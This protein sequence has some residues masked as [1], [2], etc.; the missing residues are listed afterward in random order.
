MDK[1]SNGATLGAFRILHQIGEGG[2]ARVYKAYQPSME[3]YVA[4]KVLPSS[5]AEDPQ[6]VSRFIREARTIAALEHRNILPVIDFGEERGITYMAMRFVEGGTLKELLSKGRLNLHDCVDLITQICSA[7]DYAHRRGVIHRDVKP[8]NVILDGEGAA[9]L[10]DF[11]IAKVVGK[12]ADLTATGAAIG[13]P[14][15]MAPEQAM[16]GDIDGRTDIYALGIMLYEMVVGRVPFQADTPMA[17]LM[18]HLRDPLPLPRELDPT[19]SESV[20][21]VIIKALAK[22]PADRFQKANEMADAFRKAVHATVQNIESSTL[23]TLI[24]ELQTSR[25]EL[26]AHPV[27]PATP[28]GQRTPASDPRIKERMEQDYIEGLSAYWVRDWLKACACFQAVLE[29][30]PTYKDAANRLQEVEKQMHLAE[31]YEQAQG[32]MQQRNWQAAQEKLNDLVQIDHSYQESAAMLRTVELHIELAGLY[33]QAEQLH[34]AGQWQA[35]VKIFE[36]IKALDPSA[37]D[38]KGLLNKARAA[39]AEQQKLE[40]VK[41]TYQRG[42]ETLEAGKWKDALKLFEQVKTQQS[43]FG[44]VDRLIQRVQDEINKTKIRPG[45]KASTTLKIPAAEPVPE[46]PVEAEAPPAAVVEEPKP[47]RKS[48][49]GGCALGILVIIFLVV[50]WV[51]SA[52]ARGELPWLAAAIGLAEPTTEAIAKPGPVKPF[53]VPYHYDNF[54]QSSGT[55]DTTL[56]AIGGNCDPFRQNGVLIKDGILTL[57]N[58]PSADVLICQLWARHGER[59]WAVDVGAMEAH[60]DFAELSQKGDVL[61]TIS[62]VTDKD[63]R[64]MQ[65]ICGLKSYADGKIVKYFSA[66]EEKNGINTGLAEDYKEAEY[67]RWYT[68]QLQLDPETMNFACLAGGE[69]VGSFT[70]VDADLYR[71]QQFGRF[72]ETVRQPNAVARTLFDDVRLI[73]ASELTPVEQ[74]AEGINSVGISENCPQ[75]IKGWLAEFFTNTGVKGKPTVCTDISQVKM[76]WGTGSPVPGMIPVDYFSARFSHAEKFEGGPYRFWLESDDGA[77]LWVDD[78]LVIDHWFT[79][80]STTYSADLELEPGVHQLRV[81]Y[82]ENTD[83]SLI[84][85]EWQ[86]DPDHAWVSAKTCVPPPLGLVAWWAGDGNGRNQSPGEGLHIDPDVSFVKGMVDQAFNFSPASPPASSGVASV[87]SSI[88]FPGLK[89]VSVEAWVRLGTTP[90][91]EENTEMLTKLM[92]VRVVAE[93]FIF[94]EG[95]GSLAKDENGY[96]RFSL[97]IDGKHQVITSPDKLP[98]G[99]YIHVAGTYDGSWMVLYWNGKKVSAKEVS[100]EVGG[101][102]FI[103]LSS[104]KN[105]LFGTLD[106]VSLYLGA[107]SQEAI[108]AIYAAGPNG[109]CK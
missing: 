5:F 85:L 19:I 22:E 86:R 80:P 65:V 69:L 84:R 53:T 100:G 98:R 81:E 28:S 2:M 70:P 21:V 60:L 57:V 8:S 37:G 72:L 1:L 105:P 34:Q 16:G 79:Q 75:E 63:D 67:N 15:Y 89:S 7:L 45:L 61:Q 33:A 11:G 25:P 39:L 55:V 97:V 41:S 68:F 104:T 18:A 90:P 40:K 83:D 10:M 12:G 29:V 108:Q 38:R 102:N 47:D 103:S 4:L 49:L 6:F 56:W 58:M 24:Q 52:M 9:Y 43:G 71:K 109:K 51:V 59:V 101:G 54:S 14:A 91:G 93:N 48:K 30:D 77:R 23:I 88:T 73:P 64:H 92:R 82:F 95:M 13:T 78:Q 20:E 32:A 87:E 42:L 74:P 36:R 66:W 50:L 35:V 99:E 44:D 46:P 31:L 96:L 3:R 107:L 94:M 76:D 106:E 62:L 27:T 26:P 17:V